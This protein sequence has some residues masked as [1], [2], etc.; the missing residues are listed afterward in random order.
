MALVARLGVLVVGL[1][2]VGASGVIDAAAGSDNSDQE[3]QAASKETTQALGKTRARQLVSKVAGRVDAAIVASTAARGQASDIEIQRL[4][5][6]E[7]RQILGAEIDSTIDL[8]IHGRG[9]EDAYLELVSRGGHVDLRDGHARFSGDPT[10]FRS[11][12]R[13]A[14]YLVF[15][16]DPHHRYLIECAAWASEAETVL[17]ASDGEV[18]F[19]VRADE[20]V[21]LL[22][23]S[24]N[25][26]DTATRITVV[27]SADRPEWFLEGCELTSAEI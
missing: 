7:R 19:E 16:A 4:S 5:S 10:L 23:R 21:S 24:E 1:G 13:P 9:V 12:L 17:S 14:A 6:A 2:L 22:Y 27:V 15:K 18:V 25:N 11:P 8:P 26:E 20:G 3:S